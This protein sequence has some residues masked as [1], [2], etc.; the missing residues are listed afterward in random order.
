MNTELLEA[1]T[2]LEEEKNISVCTMAKNTDASA[3][4]NGVHPPKILAAT[5]IYPL[6]ATISATNKFPYPIER[7][8]PAIAE[9]IPLTIIAY[10]LYLFVLIPQV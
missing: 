2:I 1:L 7:Y 8:A 9:S 10:I 5:P 6:P 4:P 3:P